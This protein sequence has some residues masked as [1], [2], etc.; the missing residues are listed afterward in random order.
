MTI[1]QCKYILA[2]ADMGSFSEA[3]KSIYIA[4]SSL[5]LAIKEL[6]N[7]LNIKI[8]ERS[9]R[10]IHIT[11]E[12]AEFIRYARQ[13]VSQVN[14]VEERYRLKPGDFQKFSVSTQHYDFVAE[15]FV[16]L[17]QDFPDQHYQL[18]IN[19]TKTYEVIRDVEKLSSDL[20]ILVISQLDM[21][22]MDR[23]F[24]ENKLVFHPLFVTTAYV[25]VG[26]HH[27]FASH[28]YVKQ[29]DMLQFPY[30]TYNQGEKDSSQFSEELYEPFQH[31][32]SIKINDRA[33]LL[34]LLIATDAYTIGTGIMTSELNGGKIV[35]I[36]VEND[37]LYTIGWLSRQDI[38]CGPLA[39]RFVEILTEILPKP[40]G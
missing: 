6:E 28:K 21:A 14:A 2:I 31:N 40:I 13:I 37:S 12:G 15:A 8:F 34:N 5:S 35:S 25:F 23:L 7:E 11:K 16:R 29:E 9:N 17:V 26:G 33:T 19:E 18:S 10:G 4:Q 24:K 3:A 32:K 1:Q 39:N 27:P 30:I 20:G 38:E 36:P 22:F